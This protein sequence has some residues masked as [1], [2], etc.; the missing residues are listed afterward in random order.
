MCPYREP[1][2]RSTA[3]PFARPIPRRVPSVPLLFF[4]VANQA[5]ALFLQ[6]REELFRVIVVVAASIALL[7]GAALAF[8]C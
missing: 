8:S 6:T 2:P 3:P 5:R 7:L 1:A 4:V